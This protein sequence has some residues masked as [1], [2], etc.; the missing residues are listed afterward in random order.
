MRSTT[1]TLFV[2]VGLAAGACRSSD[3]TPTA[4]LP[5]PAASPS[6]SPTGPAVAPLDDRGLL[7]VRPARRKESVRYGAMAQDN[8]FL[9]A[10]CGATLRAPVMVGVLDL[11]YDNPKGFIAVAEVAAEQALGR[12]PPPE[13]CAWREASYWARDEPG[14]GDWVVRYPATPGLGTQVFWVPDAGAPVR[15][16]ATSMPTS[17]YVSRLLRVAAYHADVEEDPDKALGLIEAALALDPA[18][19]D[20]IE[21]EGE[22]LIGAQ[23]A[24]AVE[25]ID[26]FVK[27]HGTSPD[28]DATLATALMDVG[29]EEAV[30]RGEQLIASALERDPGN[31][32]ALAARGERLRA[33]GDGPGA[34]AAYE[35]AV[36]AHPLDPSP[37]YN[38]ATLQIAAQRPEQALEHL[39]AY[40]EAFPEDPDA[41]YLRAGLLADAKDLDGAARDLGTLQRIAPQDPQVQAL[42]VRL[43]ALRSGGAPGP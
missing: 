24:K 36:A 27:D 33:K 4:P 9:V 41:L 30:A 22:L 28:L 10:R 43:E 6:P 31:L 19:S 21:L 14:R 20:A 11:P 23:S 2:A 12:E 5:A 7:E 40:L 1:L 25:L 29:S 42:A 38:L 17:A 32:K 16:E 26:A 18:S 3:S 35:Q 15:R 34:I 39:G 37:R 8:L 13:G